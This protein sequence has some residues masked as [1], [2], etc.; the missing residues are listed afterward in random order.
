MPSPKCS[1]WASLT[2]KIFNDALDDLCDRQEK[3][4]KALF[5]RYLDRNGAP[6]SLVLYD[7]T[8]SYFEG[9]HNALGEFGYNRDGK[10]GKL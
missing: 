7:V 6:P 3:I 1:A 9:E 8:S 5:R 2:K 4:E 10:K